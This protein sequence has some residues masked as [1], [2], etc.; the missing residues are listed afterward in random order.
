LQTNQRGV[1]KLKNRTFL[2]NVFALVAF[3]LLF[4]YLVFQVLP[5]PCKPS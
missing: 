1:E 5:T 2:I 4:L 3:S